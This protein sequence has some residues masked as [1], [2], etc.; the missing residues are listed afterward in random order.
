MKK[1]DLKKICIFTTF[2]FLPIILSVICF[3]IKG[4]LTEYIDTYIIKNVFLY[5]SKNTSFIS[6]I[7]EIIERP[8]GIENDLVITFILIIALF[9][10]FNFEKRN[11][12]YHLI[13]II[14]PLYLICCQNAF[15]CYYTLPFY[16]IGLLYIAPIYSGINMNNIKL[17]L[18]LIPLTFLMG[19][20]TYLLKYKK[21]DFVQ[22]KFSEIINKYEDK[23]LLNYNFIDSGF[24]LRTNSVPNIKF[25]HRMNF[26]NFKEMEDKMNE[27]ILNKQVNFIIYAYG[28]SNILIKDDIIKQNYTLIKKEKDPR[29]DFSY[30]GLYIK[31]TNK[32][33]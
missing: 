19:K 21:E 8:L 6:L 15:H 11:L 32:E 24:Y 9:L 30:Y 20:N 28:N 16:I 17:I 3:G 2:T 4:A 5:N 33:S 22:Y 18:L 12:K 23:S 7:K 1:I 10:I 26:D 29:K 27:Y 13:I 31:K 14:I 25:F